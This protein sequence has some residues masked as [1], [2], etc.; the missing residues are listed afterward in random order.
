VAH[1]GGFA[2]LACVPAGWIV[3]L[4][5]GLNTRQAMAIG[6]AGFTAALS[7]ERME[8]IGLSPPNG[9]VLVT[10]AS[11]GV[12]STAVAILAARGYTVA[13]STGSSEA[14]EYLRELG[15]TE[16]VDRDETSRESDR[17]LKRG[18]WAGVVDAVGGS[19]LAYALRTMLNGGSIAACGNTGGAAL[20]TTVFPFI[21]RGVN[22]LGIDSANLSLD[23]RTEIWQRLATDLRPPRLEQS[24]TREVPLE[25]VPEVLTAIYQGDVRGRL[26]VRVAE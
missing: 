19:T 25:Q 24:I 6:T 14:H 8:H 18:R 21:L 26:V 15:A 7:V 16:I 22:L 4:P 11:G 5:K 3:P 9:T 10:G 23:R 2:E 1:H 12:G 20:Q 17:P 13:A